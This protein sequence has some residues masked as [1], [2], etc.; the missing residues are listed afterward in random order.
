MSIP[1][2]LAS[3]S[4][5]R[6]DVLYAAGICPTIRVS[7]VD[8]PAA[9]ETAAKTAGA[10]VDELTVDQR[11]M[12]LAEAK[13]QAVHRAYR[14]VAA[15]AAAAT[16]ERVIAYPLRAAEVQAEDAAESGSG[17]GTPAA[18][19]E[20]Q[21]I[22]Y[23]KDRI[24]TTRDFSGVDM[25]TVTEP[26]SNVIAMQPGLTRATVG[27]LIIGCDSMFL[28]DGECYGKPHSA[29]VARERLRK[30][31]GASGELWTGHCVI[32]FATGRVARGASHAVVKFGDF[33]DKDIERY[34]ATG[35]PLEVAGSFT[36]EGFGGAFIDGI[37]GDPHGIIGISLPLLRKLTRELGVDWTDL[38][39]VKRGES[40][41]EA[42]DA[43]GIPAAGKDNLPP[44][45]NVHQPG[46]GW[47]DCAC[48]RKHW[49]TNGA[50]GILLARRD[51]S[52]G[53]VM[54]VVMQHRAAWSAEGGTWGIPGG[55]TADGESP[56]EGALRE[57]YEEAN[58]TPEDIEVVG[59]YREDHGPW[60]YTTVFAFEK[61]GH[62]VEPKANDDESKEICWIPIADVPNRKLLTAMKT[63]WP[64]FAARL[65][66]L[67][68]KY[69]AK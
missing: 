32:D 41:P 28:L 18:A 65:D 8:E 63:D 3:K 9:L 19:N 4:K 29:E 61:P 25:P 20:S 14:N 53:K 17:S 68:G 51:P 7:H 48:G 44:V 1:L 46:D 38:W 2:I 13:A 55:A 59:S 56:I 37:E 40:A 34:I 22:D 5:P 39:N 54:D 35:E 21:S 16:G 42:A 66:E 43:A 36:L 69:A 27:P 49:G 6:R 57:S 47:V 52:T 50:S 12:I 45:E 10:A 24:A 62:T 23:S 33:T 58:I 11:V 64:R 67:A 30:M 26:I 31:R 60:A 15:T